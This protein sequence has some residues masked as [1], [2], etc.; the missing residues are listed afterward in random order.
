MN[1]G[2]MKLKDNIVFINMNILQLKK[3]Y[4]LIKVEK[5]NKLNLHMHF[6]VRLFDSKQKKLRNQKKD[7]MLLQ[8]KTNK[9]H[10]KDDKKSTYKE[11]L[12]KIVNEKLGKIEELT[13]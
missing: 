13:R 5:W 9:N 3:H 6:S 8:I 4:H 12:E 2:S 11:L 10:Q 7:Q 1:N